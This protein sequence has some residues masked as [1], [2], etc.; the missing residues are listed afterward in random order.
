MDRS[1]PSEWTRKQFGPVEIRWR[2]ATDSR[3]FAV[4]ALWRGDEI[5]AGAVDPRAPE[6]S[7]SLD[8]GSGKRLVTGLLRC[9]VAGDRSALYLD[10]EAPGVDVRDERLAPDPGPPPPAEPDEEEN[11]ATWVDAAPAP[12][13]LFPYLYV[14]PWPRV[15]ADQ[16]ADR[17]VLF[18][19]ADDPPSAPEL[20]RQLVALKQAGDRLGMEELAI[21]FVE[22]RQ[23]FAGQY[24]ADVRR[25]DGP[26]R[27]FAEFDRQARRE[28]RP[29]R[30]GLERRVA[31]LT[32]ESWPT[33]VA[34]LLDPSSAYRVESTR[35]WMSAFALLVALG[36]DFEELDRLLETLAAGR[37]L[38]RIA[39]VGRAPAGEE[40]SVERLRAGLR[41]TV[42]LPAAVFPL[43]P[44]APAAGRSETPVETIVP[45]AIGDLRLVQQRLVGYSLGEVAA[46]EN[47]QSGELRDTVRRRLSRQSELSSSASGERTERA[48]EVGSDLAAASRSVLWENFKTTYETTYGPPATAPARGHFE[49][50]VVGGEGEPLRANRDGLE[51][52]RAI[53]G[54]GAE[55]V[56]RSVET[57]RAS[58]RFEEAEETV[59]H[60]FDG[61]GRADHVRGVYRWVNRVCEV[62]VVGLGRRLLIELLVPDPA[63]RFVRAE[64]ALAGEPV[65]APVAPSTLGLLSPLDLSIDPASPLFWATLATRFEALELEPP[66]APRRSASVALEGYGGEVGLE[67]PLPASYRAR[68]A[69]VAAQ[70]REG[71]TAGSVSGLIGSKRFRL[72]AGDAGAADDLELDGESETVPLALAGPLAD[73]PS[74]G[75]DFGLTVRMECELEPGALERWQ[76]SGFR[77]IQA[78]YGRQRERF[79]DA[80][81]VGAP[82]RALASPS[83]YRQI[84]QRELSR[85]VVAQLLGRVRSRLASAADLAVAEPRYLQTFERAFEWPAMTYT[86]DL[87]ASAA[88]RP[89]EA[90]WAIGRHRGADELFSA[91]LEARAA[92]VLLPVRPELELVIPWLLD[93]GEIWPGDPELTPAHATSVALVNDLKSR[94]ADAEPPRTEGDA[95]RVTVPT[96]MLYLEHDSELPWVAAPRSR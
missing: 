23:P 76:V 6:L 54:R 65:C 96:T 37:L 41:A 34:Y 61:R 18:P 48:R 33:I 28:T 9:A 71:V 53:I 30:E 55:R 59:R 93:C 91:F 83:G 24:V 12:A 7:F 2:P 42:V 29:T 40:W 31:E 26:L 85:D 57:R 4:G 17:F 49:L 46:I 36:Y 52:A 78:G 95:W 86:F 16:L 38:E 15:P 32:G 67:I 35:V 27:V 43:P 72:K 79:F 70:W 44:G 13:S 50:G 21:A 88:G 22:G 66:P 20:Y 62:R 56:A 64:L 60:R 39:V 51:L 94:A 47:V 92:R 74:L 68:R 75:R 63:A 1:V 58:G 5:V 73:A 11:L 82:G 80:A 14:R 3:G 84:E 87:L 8:D 19:E 45:Y 69:L 81:G 90:R 77:A 25:L 10:L 89:A